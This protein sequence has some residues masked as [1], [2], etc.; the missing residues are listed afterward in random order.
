MRAFLEHVFSCRRHRYLD[1]ELSHRAYRYDN[2][3]RIDVYLY[4]KQVGL[5]L[6]HVENYRGHMVKVRRFR[7][8]IYLQNKLCCLYR[9]LHLIQGIWSWFDVFVPTYM[10]ICV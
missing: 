1:S 10:T 3:S 2:M 9:I 5:S 8:Y 6:L 7:A 4:A